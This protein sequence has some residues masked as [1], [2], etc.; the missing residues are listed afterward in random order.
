MS[1]LWDCSKEI[2]QCKNPPECAGYPPLP[3]R[4][5]VQ[6]I[7]APALFIR[8]L[9]TEVMISHRKYNDLLRDFKPSVFLLKQLKSVSTGGHGGFGCVCVDVSLYRP[10]AE[11]QE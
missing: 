8:S 7:P 6:A 9:F 11:C 4:A 5:G 10:Y 1:K 2:C 3:E